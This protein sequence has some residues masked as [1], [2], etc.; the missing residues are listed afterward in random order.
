MMI[1]KKSKGKGKGRR[2]IL[3]PDLGLFLGDAVGVYVEI[4]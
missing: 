2:Y 3:R 1:S 4:A